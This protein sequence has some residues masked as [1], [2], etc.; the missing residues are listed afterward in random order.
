M[1]MD[2]DDD[3]DDESTITMLQIESI[4]DHDIGLTSLSR[5][6]GRKVR[7]FDLAHGII[8]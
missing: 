4:L 3:D 6:K 1:I 8:N 7:G 2:D 5:D